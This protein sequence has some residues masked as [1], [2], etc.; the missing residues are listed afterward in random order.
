MAVNCQLDSR[1][2]GRER[3]SDGKDGAQGE[4]DGEVELTRGRLNTN[5]KG[6]DL[7]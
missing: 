1:A 5:E 6:Q 3:E 2:G 7:F 4:Q